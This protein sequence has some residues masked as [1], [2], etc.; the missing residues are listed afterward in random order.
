MPAP[1]PPALKQLRR[2]YDP[3]A[4]CSALA[5]ALIDQGR[6][7]DHSYQHTRAFFARYAPDVDVD[8]YIALLADLGGHCDCEIGLNV[9]GQYVPGA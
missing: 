2:L 1:K 9:C 7:C 6:P 4:L 8:R 3:L 5:R